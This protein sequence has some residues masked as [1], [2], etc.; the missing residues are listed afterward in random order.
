M[1]DWQRHR[2]TFFWS[3]RGGV[4]Y[5]STTFGGGSV[6]ASVGAT[7]G[8]RANVA[9]AA[10]CVRKLKEIKSTVVDCTAHLSLICGSEAYQTRI[11]GT[12]AQRCGRSIDARLNSPDRSP[13]QQLSICCCDLSTVMRR[14]VSVDTCAEHPIVFVAFYRSILPPQRVS[15][16]AHNGDNGRKTQHRH[17]EMRCMHICHCVISF[18]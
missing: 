15:I 6:H 8:C 9:R 18:L 17:R 14:I 16:V 11:S 1:A 7:R 2:P 3:Y 4:V 12:K 13:S 10:R 5:C